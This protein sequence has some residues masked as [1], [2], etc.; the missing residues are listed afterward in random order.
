MEVT[1]EKE[2]KEKKGQ[3]KKEKQEWGEQIWRVEKGAEKGKG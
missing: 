3:E 2:E 1:Q